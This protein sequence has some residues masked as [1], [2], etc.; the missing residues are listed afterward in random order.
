VGF[1]RFSDLGAYQQFIALGF[2][3]VSQASRA[4]C[5]SHVTPRRCQ[6]AAGNLARHAADCGDDEE[7]QAVKKPKPCGPKGSTPM[8]LAVIAAIDLVRWELSLGT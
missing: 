6:V 4:G 3:L 5:D 2:R 7:A 8:I 1:L